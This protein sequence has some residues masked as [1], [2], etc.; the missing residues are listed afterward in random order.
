MNRTT[1]C[2]SQSQPPRKSTNRSPV[3]RIL[4]APVRRWP[5]WLIAVA[6]MAGLAGCGT[7]VEELLLQSGA[8]VARSFIDIWLTDL[9]NDLAD[10]MEDQDEEPADDETDDG[11]ADDDGGTTDEPG[12]DELTGDPA[13]GETLYASC[14]G[15]HCADGAGDCMPGAS[16]LAGA[17]AETLDAT[18]QGSGIHPDLTNQEIVDLEAYLATLGG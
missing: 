4:Q 10:R 15:C 5:A 12:F 3:D 2:T 11:D 14:A 13:S 18:L 1:E 6:L 16:A 17:S 7:N 9:A 8:S